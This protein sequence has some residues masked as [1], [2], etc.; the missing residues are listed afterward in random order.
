MK[1]PKTNR[2]VLTSAIKNLDDIYLV[3]MRERLLH[4]C[5]EV[6]ENKDQVRMMMKDSMIHPD[7]YI[8]A[9][10]AIQKEINFETN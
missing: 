10:E 5:D 2:Q 3:F 7:L 6:L 9:M 8:K 4:C 1:K